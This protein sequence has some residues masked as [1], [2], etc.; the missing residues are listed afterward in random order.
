LLI[1]DGKCIL[2]RSHM[3]IRMSEI[4]EILDPNNS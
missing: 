3:Q 2:H 1:K 4:A